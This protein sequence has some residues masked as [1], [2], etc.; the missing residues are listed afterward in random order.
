MTQTSNV[1]AIMLQVN[2]LQK[3]VFVR[4]HSEAHQNTLEYSR[5]G[6]LSQSDG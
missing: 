4:A 6:I 1:Y 5:Q 3:V 2:S